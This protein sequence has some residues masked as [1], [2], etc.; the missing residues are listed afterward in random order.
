MNH[1]N[2]LR[3]SNDKTP[4]LSIPPCTGKSIY[5]AGHTLIL[6]SHSVVANCPLSADVVLISS[7]GLRF[8]THC[9][10]LG[11]FTGAFPLHIAPVDGEDV[12]MP[13]LD[14]EALALFLRFVHHH[15]QPDLSKA[16]F[17][18]LSQL[19]EAVEKYEVYSAT[20]ICKVSFVKDECVKVFQY[21]SKHGYHN[22]MNDAARIA[23]QNKYL[24]NRIPVGLYQR[25]DLQAAW[26]RYTEHWLGLFDDCYNEP[27]PVLH[28]GGEKECRMWRKFRNVVL[29]QV[30]REAVIFL[31]F[32]G[33]VDGARHYLKDCR[34]CGIRADRWTERVRR[35]A[36]EVE[37]MGSPFTSF[38]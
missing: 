15:R 11:E 24:S 14:S 36:W 22:L 2:V 25:P 5:D 8:G 21:A 20:E 38:L 19:A 34:H 9:Q 23:V 12:T 3:E 28:R 35:N 32:N 13:G 16:S 10:N 18:A 1:S 29:A 7:D 33:L 26:G 27:P 30:K 37:S 4:Q 6:R 17:K 31:S